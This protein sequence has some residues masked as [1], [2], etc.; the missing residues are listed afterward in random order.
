M[1]PDVARQALEA[2]NWNLEM[3]VNMQ[4]DLSAEQHE[5]QME[6]IPPLDVDVPVGAPPPVPPE[7]TGRASSTQGSGRT[8]SSTAT[9]TTSNNYVSE[10]GV[11]APIPPVRQVL[12]DDSFEMPIHH[13]RSLRSFMS[14]ASSSSSGFRDPFRDFRQEALFRESRL[15]E[16]EA[17]SLNLQNV[18][19]E[20]VQASGG[21]SEEEKIRSLEDLFRPPLDLMFNGSLEA[22]KDQGTRDNKWI[23]V[24]I[25]NPTEFHCQ[26][27]NRDIWR[28]PA[29]K[30]II[31]EH[32]IFWQ[33]DYRQREAQRYDQFYKVIQYPYVSALDPLT[34]EL[35]KVWTTAELSDSN[36]FCESVTDFLQDRPSPRVDGQNPTAPSLMTAISSS[37]SSKESKELNI[38]DMSE[39]EQIKAAIEASLQNHANSKCKKEFVLDDDDDDEE[40][41]TF[42]SF[43]GDDDESSASVSSSQNNNKLKNI[44][45]KGICTKQEENED[46]KKY[47]GVESEM[48]ELSIRFPDGQ[49][50]VVSFPCDT[51][52]KV[53]NISS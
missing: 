14:S 48:C 50:E 37:S 22:A 53:S 38:A 18:D 5:E 7:R 20:G 19:D 10:D 24:N 29:V 36:H 46:Y 30:A 13:T 23:M 41:E 1:S 27:L 39:E 45:N 4:F 6:T 35:L 43:D 11:R 3:A 17:N 32:F 16:A 8:T 31:R 52:L 33:M 12:V 21:A 9:S 51:K 34:G 44:D 42:E 15:A 40:L 47:L 49:K 26:V 28:N 2:C 25:Q